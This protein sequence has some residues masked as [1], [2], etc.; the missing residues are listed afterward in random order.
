MGECEF[1][2]QCRPSVASV[3]SVASVAS[4]VSV[5]E[6]ADA[7]LQRLPVD[8]VVADSALLSLFSR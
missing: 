6:V 5:A 8:L 2:C 7:Q 3:V 4:V 1:S